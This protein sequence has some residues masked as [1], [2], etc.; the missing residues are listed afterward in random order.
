MMRRIFLWLFVCA[1]GVVQAL[2]QIT[3]GGG[4]IPVGI[5]A[6]SSIWYGTNSVAGGRV[7]WRP[8]IWT[9]QHTVCMARKR[10]AGG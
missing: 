7:G 10:T 2:A 3:V 4:G 6:G 5:P 9:R 8:P 1:A